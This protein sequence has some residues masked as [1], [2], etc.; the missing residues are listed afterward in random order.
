[1]LLF[2][3]FFISK[4]NAQKLYYQEGTEITIRENTI[5]YVTDSGIVNE[6]RLKNFKEDHIVSNK[7]ENVA[8]NKKSKPL[9]KKIKNSWAANISEKKIKTEPKSEPIQ[10]ITP[11]PDNFFLNYQKGEAISASVT[12]HDHPIYSI[13]NKIFKLPYGYLNNDNNKIIRKNFFFCKDS[14]LFQ[15]KTR[16]P[17]FE[18]I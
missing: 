8:C 9:P 4:I 17:P 1:M 10:F 2:L 15:Y 6:Q 7:T 16:P 13:S 18:L 12:F 3:F 11:S 5:V 14:Y